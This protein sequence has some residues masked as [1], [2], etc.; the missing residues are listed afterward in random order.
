MRN[1]SKLQNYV[2]ISSK[3]IKDVYDVGH[4][5]FVTSTLSMTFQADTGSDTGSD[6]DIS[7]HISQLIEIF[8]KEAICRVYQQ[9][10]G[11][12]ILGIL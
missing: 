6:T 2:G 10:F 12:I 8:A 3:S 1:W 7:P 4:C 9:T 5:D 11:H